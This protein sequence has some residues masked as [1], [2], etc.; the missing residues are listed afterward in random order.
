VDERSTTDMWAVGYWEKY[1]ESYSFHTLTEHWDGTGWTI[2]PSPNSS[3][4]ENYLSGVAALAP[5]DVWAVG[6][7][8]LSPY[9]TLVEHW[10]GSSWSIIQRATFK[11]LLFGVAALAPNDVWAVGTKGYPGRA[12]IEHWDGSVW[13][14]TY[15]PFAGILRAITALGRRDIWSVGQ[16]FNP[17]DPFGDFTLAMHFDGTSWTRFH[18]PSPLRI[19]TEDQNWLT[20]VS[21]VAAD[22]VWAV[23]RAGDHDWAISDVTLVEHWD[24]QRWRLVPSPSPGGYSQD[25]D[26][27]GVAALSASDVWAVGSIGNDPFQPLA[28]RWDGIAWTQ[29]KAPP[30][31]GE[32][33]AIT[34]LPSAAGLGLWASGN[35]EKRDTYIGTL[36]EHLC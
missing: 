30:S 29:V 8:G 35:R 5:D 16:R 26:L 3:D 27:W 20:S 18:S 2:I 34:G 12:L 24:G 9:H 10:D 11:G 6:T 19:H 32:L 7:E 36:A 13:T 23:G 4:P 14:A 31:D 17:V 1:P 33:L 25:S 28:E 15:L 22:N 21:A